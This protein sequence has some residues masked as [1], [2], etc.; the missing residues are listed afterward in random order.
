MSALRSLAL[1]IELATE[2]RDE[3]GRHLMQAQR[4]YLQ[5][6][7]Q[8]EQ[9]ANYAADSEARWVNSAQVSMTTGILQHHYQFMDRLHHA[10]GLQDGA[11]ANLQQQVEVE[12]RRVQEAEMRLVVL[13]KLLAKKQM[14]RAMVMARREQRQT[15]EFAAMQHARAMAQLNSGEMT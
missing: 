7:N 2:K 10:I 5:G 14:E 15:D 4:A 13:Q 11:L 9:L 6:Q 8:L 1:A 12:K 3:A